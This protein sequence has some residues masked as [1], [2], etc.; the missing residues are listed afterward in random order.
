MGRIILI[1]F[2]VLV[3]LVDIY[4]FKQIFFKENNI[5]KPP[6]ET[7]KVKKTE[8][9]PVKTEIKKDKTKETEIKKEEILDKKPQ[10]VQ[11]KKPENQKEKKSVEK[12]KPAEGYMVAKVFVNLRAEPDVNSEVITVVKKGDKVKIIGKKANHWKRV[13]YPSDGRVYE[14][15]VDDR[16][17]IPEESPKS[18]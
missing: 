13:L 14:G 15:W 3:I 8:K 5:P 4:L 11:P 9:E 7:V 6:T 17:F 12:G 10:A 2:I 16:F 1:T 18:E